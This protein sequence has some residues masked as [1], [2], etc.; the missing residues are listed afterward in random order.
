M[1][2]VLPPPVAI[3][4]PRAQLAAAHGQT[5]VA[6]FI[7]SPDV[8]VVDLLGGAGAGGY[9]QRRRWA[10]SPGEPIVPLG[11]FEDALDEY[12]EE[13]A[14]RGLRPAFM[15]VRDPEP[16]VRRGMAVTEIADEAVIDVGD[17]SLVGPARANVRH[18]VSSGRRH[19]LTF[20]AYEPRMADQLRAISCA[21]LATKRGGELG[22]TL[23][24]HDDVT[25][26][27][28]DGAT[29]LW[30]VLDEH[31]DVQAWCTW[32]HYLGGL[33]RVLDVMRRRPD[34]PNPAMDLLIASCLE[35]YRDMGLLR[36]SLASV[37]RPHGAT[38]ELVYP[39]RSL[40]AYKQKFD[41]RWEPRWLAVPRQRH[42]P[43]ALLAICGA[44]C[45]GGVRRAILRNG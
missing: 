13:I 42:V 4:R 21:W 45:P 12:L 24:R 29:D 18:A 2:A 28:R 5:G 15:A 25:E 36:V 17:F 35:M 16:F 27:L 40:R 19:G 22:F 8:H 41:P 33:G 38:A 32:R 3:T 7:A 31:G 14:D 11:A 1:T 37:P 6:P 23:S 34:A 43:L 10:I 20:A 44:Y 30:T 9:A 39:T 26:Q